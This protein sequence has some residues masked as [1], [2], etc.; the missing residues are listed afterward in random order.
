MDSLARRIRCEQRSTPGQQRVTALMVVIFRPRERT[1]SARLSVHYC[2][3]GLSEGRAGDVHG[4]D[5]LPWVPASQGVLD[6]FTLLT[7]LGWQV[8]VYGDA[9]RS[10][11][12]ACDERVLPLH[13]FPWRRATGRAGLQRNAVYLVRPDG[14]VALADASG[15]AQRLLLSRC[16]P[17]RLDAFSFRLLNR[18]IDKRAVHGGEDAI[19]RRQ[20]L[21]DAT[22]ATLTSDG[23]RQESAG[24]T[25]FRMSRR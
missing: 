6:N 9:T 21:L 12:T 5:R 14:Y 25:P 2:D 19:L 4:G 18:S 20:S 13:V 22:I 3:S 24:G 1:A 10:T 16:A 7:S 17:A 11:Q 15:R 8:H 23:D